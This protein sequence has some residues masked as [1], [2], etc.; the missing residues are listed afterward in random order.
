MYYVSSSPRVHAKLR[1][2]IDDAA[3]LNKLSPVITFQEALELPYFQVVVKEA[4]RL[5]P[6]GM[7]R[8]NA[9]CSCS[10]AFASSANAYHH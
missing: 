5:Y 10:L 9:T 1:R 6:A 2:E 8:A 4:L 7:C 3:K